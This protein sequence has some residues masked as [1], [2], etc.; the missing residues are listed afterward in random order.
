[1]RPSAKRAVALPGRRQGIEAEGLDPEAARVDDLEDHRPGG[2]H[3][4][5]HGGGLRDHAVD[6]GHQGLRL[7]TGLVEGGPAVLQALQL[8]LGVVEL[9]LGDGARGGELAEALYPTLDDVDLLVELA[10]ALAH[11]RDVDGLDRRGYGRQHV[12]FPHLG[13]EPGKQAGRRRRQAPAH[14]GLHH[15]AGVRVGDDPARQL[16]R[17]VERRRFGHGRAQ[18]QQPLRRLGHEH[19]AVRQ[20][21][22]EIRR[23][24]QGIEQGR[25][26]HRGVLGRG[27][28][29]LV[30]VGEGS[31]PQR[32]RDRHRHDGHGRQAAP[33]T[34]DR[35]D[36][37]P[38][39]ERPGGDQHQDGGPLQRAAPSGPR[40]RR[41]P[42]QL[43]SRPAG[44]ARRRSPWSPEWSRP[45]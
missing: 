43:R 38:E 39:E 29:V 22:G 25:A 5:G 31:R 11:V 21:L 30:A 33:A 41:T 36:Q 32:Q 17:P 3:L 19:R 7:L 34:R 24:L 23:G 13:P 20:S 45:R 6:R 26:L 28:V 14:R 40:G 35:G 1:M 37:H 9:G 44:P 2:R 15:A 16:D 10:L 8:G 4:A 27:A 12:A 42:C 18:D